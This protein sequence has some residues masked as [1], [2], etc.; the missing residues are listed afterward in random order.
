MKSKMKLLRGNI[1]ERLESNELAYMASKFKKKKFGKNNLLPV[2]GSSGNQVFIVSSGQLRVYLSYEGREFTLRFL[3]RGD[4][5]TTHTRA[6][7]ETVVDSELMLIDTNTFHQELMRQ[8]E[9]ALNMTEILGEILAS[10]WD[11]IESLIFQDVKSRLVAFI[12]SLGK[13]RGG[14]IGER[15]EF[16]CDLTIEDI[17]LVIASSRQTTSSLFNELIKDGYILR[18]DKNKIIIPD[19]K[20]L[21]TD[22]LKFKL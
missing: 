5:F 6:S 16:D 15:V 13:E 21:K 17:A 4:I 11:V 8:P 14:K 10:S 20:R 7:I 9:M 12:I 2:S 3:E 18:P 1:T 19:E 22:L